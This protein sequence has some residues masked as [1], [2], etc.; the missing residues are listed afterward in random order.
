[1]TVVRSICESIYELLQEIQLE[2]QFNDPPEMVEYSAIGSGAEAAME[3][4]S[5]DYDNHPTTARCW[6]W[7][8]HLLYKRMT[9]A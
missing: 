8:R 4:L 9:L 6:R 1:M 7:D 2:T 5:P 3:H